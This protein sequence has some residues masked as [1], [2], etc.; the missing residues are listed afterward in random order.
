[1]VNHLRVAHVEDAPR[2]EL[3]KWSGGDYLQPDRVRAE[4]YEGQEHPVVE[5]SG[6][7]FTSEG[8]DMLRRY[9]QHF[10]INHTDPRIRPP[11]W[12]AE[13]I[14]EFRQLTDAKEGR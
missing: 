3:G 12:V 1:M 14:P 10:V 11:E 5:V 2:V 6:K 7:M 8:Q 9:T 4:W 13:L